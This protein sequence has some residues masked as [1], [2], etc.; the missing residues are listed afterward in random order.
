MFFSWEHYHNDDLMR[1]CPNKR[2]LAARIYPMKYTELTPGDSQ[3][4][5]SEVYI[6]FLCRNTGVSREEVHEVARHSGIS[7]RRMAEYL[8]RKLKPVEQ[9]DLD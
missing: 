1:S 5:P 6:E 2:H 4:H 8:V 9:N 3:S 7:V